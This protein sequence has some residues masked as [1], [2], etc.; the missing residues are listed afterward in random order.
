[1]LLPI[2]YNIDIEQV[3]RHHKNPTEKL[4]IRAS[5]RG[6]TV[7]L[8]INAEHTDQQS[9]DDD[10]IGKER[11][12]CMSALTLMQ[13]PRCF[14]TLTAAPRRHFLRVINF[15]DFWASQYDS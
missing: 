12:C 5:S 2:S 15:A 9:G 6:A 4:D 1:M 14:Q 13:Q 10:K 3:S 8:H 11:G 7:K